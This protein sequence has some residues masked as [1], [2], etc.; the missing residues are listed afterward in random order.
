MEPKF[1]PG[2]WRLLS[3]RRIATQSGTFYLSYGR[4]GRSNVPL[5]HNF[6]ELDNNARLVAAAPKLFDALAS[7]INIVTHPQATK[8]DMRM[9]ANEAR[10]ALIEATEAEAQSE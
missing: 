4:D 10:A 1:T 8:A 7:L 5:F 6:V 2:P 3:G 9:I